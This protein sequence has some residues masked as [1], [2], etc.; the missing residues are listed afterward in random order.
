MNIA[1]IQSQLKLVPDSAL[2]GYVQNPDGQVPSY[3]ALSEISRRTLLR[4]SAAQKEAAPTES[5]AEQTVAG[6]SDGI[7]GIPL[8]D[9][10]M[11]SEQSMAAGG[12]VAFAGPEGSLVKSGFD[13]YGTIT[14]SEYKALPTEL[15][16]A[17]EGKIQA[18][19]GLD[20]IK[21]T[22]VKTGKTEIKRDPAASAKVAANPVPVASPQGG[23]G[24]VPLNDYAA[25]QK[26]YFANYQGSYETPN[27]MQEFDTPQKQKPVAPAPAAGI[28]TGLKNAFSDITVPDRVTLDRA[29]M[30]GEAPTLSG[31]QTLRKDAYSKAN[32]NENLYDTGLANITAQKEELKS[33]GKDEA[34]GEFLM[35]LGFGAAAGTNQNALTNFSQAAG[36]AGK[37]LIGSLSKLKDKEEKLNEREFAMMDAQNKF[38]Q[39]GADADLRNLQEQTKDYR[40]AQREY[41]K[42]DAQLQDS[43]IGRVFSLETSKAN[44]VGQNARAEL[45]ARLQQQQINVSAFNAETQRMAANKPELFNT[46]LTN[47]ESDPAY[48][49]ATGAVR[50]KM[51]TDAVS[52]AKSTSSDNDNTL[53]A[54]AGKAV[55]ESLTF[56]PIASN[57]KKLMAE[58]PTGSKAKAYRDRLVLEEL[59]RLKQSVSGSAS[60]GNV[61]DFNSLG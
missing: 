44:E 34:I 29:E 7:A 30:V 32:V 23:A 28:T 1:K 11:F 56:G 4:K 51:V 45:S 36:P 13:P 50:N 39:T 38:R 14:A 31:I 20:A 9:P 52:D 60:T 35:N 19:H 12:I 57:Y 41:A 53:R 48:I 17:F 5:V 40:S 25:R 3:L 55:A 18:P 46:I 37:G 8:Q 58:D 26:D 42:T 24:N 49:N 27:F 22:D 61:V 21:L 16:V 10:S 54:Q 47:L 59:Q 33:K 43:Y 2:A 6:V 15:Q